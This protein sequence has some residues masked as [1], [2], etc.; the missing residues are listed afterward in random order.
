MFSILL[1]L[2]LFFQL[3]GTIFNDQSYNFNSHGSLYVL[4]FPIS[5]FSSLIGILFV[6]NYKKSK[7]SLILII[8][9]SIIMLISCIGSAG[10]IFDIKRE[11]FLLLFQFL[12]PMFW[13]L[14]GQICGSKNKNI[15]IIVN[16][17][18]YVV[19]I[20]IPIQ[21]ISSLK[22]DIP[23]L[24]PSIFVFSIYQHLQ[25]V[26]TIFIGIYI[27]SVFTLWDKKYIKVLLF[28]SAPLIGIYS[29]FSL[30]MLTHFSLYSG[31]LTFIIYYFIKRSESLP[32]LLAVI[33]FSVSIATYTN[34]K[35]N[36]NY[37]QKYN[38]KESSLAKTSNKTHS[39]ISGR[40]EFWKHYLSRMT[41]DKKSLFLGQVNRTNRDEYPSSH[42]YF[43]DLS[44]NFG[45][46]SLIPIVV[47]LIVTFSRGLQFRQKIFEDPTLVGLT[48]VTFFLVVI[49]NSL[50]V[51]LRQP[52]PGII[53]FFL[54][55]MLLSNFS[56]T[57]SS[58]IESKVR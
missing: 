20:I 45:V 16:T 41:V 28:I 47:F 43:L 37:L 17:F 53:T 48:F 24:S 15:R 34:F 56:I 51:G 23:V 9:I 18:F 36:Q 32:I 31:L 39:N 13:L 14:L 42:N 38:F 6:F 2:P 19:I 4:P 25:Y 22:S 5:I 44:Y 26:P 57:P 27:L 7:E 52:Y 8:T 46:I 54:W 33:I 50:K 49:D 12:F 3:D 10:N 30:S 29:Q 40:V 55:G 35:N 1:T 11:K 21:I 58:T